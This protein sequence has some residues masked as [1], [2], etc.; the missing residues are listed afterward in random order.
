MF[1]KGVHIEYYWKIQKWSVDILSLLLTEVT[2][3][4][5]MDK[6]INKRCYLHYTIH[7]FVWVGNNQIIDY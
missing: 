6:H 5:D 7:L 1:L 2:S 3:D 4:K